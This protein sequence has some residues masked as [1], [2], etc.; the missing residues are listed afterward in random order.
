MPRVQHGFDIAIRPL[1]P[2]QM[3][4]GPY[5]LGYKAWHCG[6]VLGNAILLSLGLSQTGIQPL[7][8]EI[9]SEST[10]WTAGAPGFP[11]CYVDS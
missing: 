10:G 3:Q 8:S 5:R 9:V 6:T 1:S 7:F 4:S 2:Q 11:S